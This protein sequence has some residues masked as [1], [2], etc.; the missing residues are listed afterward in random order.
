MTRHL[1]PQP[2]LSEGDV[3]GTPSSVVSALVCL[4]GAVLAAVCAF[5]VVRLSVLDGVR[6]LLPVSDRLPDGPWLTHV[7]AA[8]LAGIGAVLVGRAGALVGRRRRI[9]ALRD[10][11]VLVDHATG[12]IDQAIPYLT[13]ASV[14]Q[15]FWTVALTLTTGARV[16]LVKRPRTARATGRM[17]D[18][19]VAQIDHARS[20]WVARA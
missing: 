7:C 16:V 12:K 19:M 20:G 3:L 10:R 1:P 18:L 2:D 13:I 11:L 8:L 4:A 5:A 9:V 15:S 6:G 14:Q 17:I